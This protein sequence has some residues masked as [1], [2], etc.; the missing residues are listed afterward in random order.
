MYFSV[1]SH[2]IAIA[3]LRNANELQMIVLH[4]GSIYLTHVPFEY[5]FISVI[6]SSKQ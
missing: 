5:L 1:V 4:S 6:I 3:H 2:T